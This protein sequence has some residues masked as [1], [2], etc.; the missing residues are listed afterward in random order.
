MNHVYNFVI[1][2]SA[3]NP[4]R[5][6]IGPTVTRGHFFKILTC[7]EINEVIT[8]IAVIHKPIHIQ[9]SY[10][11]TN[12]GIT[13]DTNCQCLVPLWT[14]IWSGWPFV[15]S[16]CRMK[17]WN[18]SRF[19]NPGR[20]ICKH[21]KPLQKRE[22]ITP[23]FPFLLS[24]NKLT[25][26]EKNSTIREKNPPTNWQNSSIGQTCGKKLPTLSRRVGRTTF[27]L[28]GTYFKILNILSTYSLIYLWYNILGQ[29]HWPQKS[30]CGAITRLYITW[31]L[32]KYL[33]QGFTLHLTPQPNCFNNSLK[34][35]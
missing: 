7:F 6:W 13:S 27:G 9:R 19:M 3:V 10:I 35:I 17:V 23:F 31:P 28:L 24:Y 21:K 25:R 20:T 11:N 14:V 2:A 8:K 16:K 4:R 30:Q 18:F 15:G 1:L 5:L 29:S 12:F 32:I 33:G 26:R 22:K 34:I